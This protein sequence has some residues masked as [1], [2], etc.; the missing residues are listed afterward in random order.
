MHTIAEMKKCLKAKD[1]KGYSGKSKSELHKMCMHHGCMPDAK[2][3]PKFIQKVM[4]A[5]GYRMGAMT[6]KSSAH[7]QKPLEYAREVLAHPEKHDLRTRR[8]AQFLV[9]IQKK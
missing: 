6:K 8:Q 2:D 9:N 4:G 7:H 1:V 3:P 5:K